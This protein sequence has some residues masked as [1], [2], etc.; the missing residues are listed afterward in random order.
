MKDEWS[1]DHFKSIAEDYLQ[2]T[3]AVLLKINKPFE[4]KT[5]VDYLDYDCLIDLA[6]EAEDQE[7]LERVV[8]LERYDKNDIT[9]L[10][11][12]LNNLVHSELGEYFEMNKTT[13][14]L[15]QVIN[16]S[17]VVYF[18]LPALRF[19]SFSKVL[20]KLI[21]N[22]LKSTIDRN[23]QSNPI[24][25]V[26]DEFSVFA[27]E[28]VL[29]LV[30]MG[31]GKGVH[32]VFGTQGL[33]D[34]DKVSN[35]FKNQVLNCVNTICHRLNDQQSAESVANWIGTRDAFT[36]TAQLNTKHGDAAMGTVKCEKEL[37]FI[38]ARLNKD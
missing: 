37:L 38:Q 1:S 15:Q 18:A 30:N 26:F 11:A 16:D 21:I 20:G 33:A 12:H 29:N 32:A 5:V 4:L 36:H 3:F 6:R 35:T 27:G 9:G 2:A 25:T 34:L 28:Q 22:D 14:T 31:R 19:P 13:F 17:A 7:L 8:K 10:Q 23:S 24:F